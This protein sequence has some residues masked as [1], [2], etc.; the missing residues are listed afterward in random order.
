MRFARDHQAPYAI[1]M[2]LG[3]EFEPVTNLLVRASYLRV[4][5]V[6]LGSFF[7]V[8][9]PE[10]SGQ[11]T[12]HDSNGNAGLKNTFFAGPGIP[13][14]RDPSFGI[15]FEADS[16]WNSVS[17]SLLLNLDRRFSDHFGFG[18]SY[19]WSKGI[20]DGPNPSFVLMPQDIARFDLER[21]LSADH[22]AHRFVANS[23]IEGPTGLHP[24]VNDF[25]FG[26]IIALRTPHFFTK[27]AG[28]DA[29]GDIFGNND[30]VGIEPRNTFEGDSLQSFDV[31]VS[32]SFNLSEDLKLQLIAEMFN[33]FNRVNVRFFNT[34]YGA[35]DFCPVGGPAI[36]GPGPF[37][38]EGSPN[39]RYATERA[40]NNPR[41]VQLALRLTF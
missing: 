26:F 30:R 33:A 28:F 41:Q 8:N 15:Y 29:N 16:R 35:A 2:S 21:A 25:Q 39:P 19:T 4:K 22:V 36:C 3:L 20:D 5:G 31:R 18:I 24:V 6:H 38:T 27:F 40:V 37:F 34:V 1:Q 17:D 14:T 12:V 9:Q 7:N 23:T 11:V 13:G 32:R 10:P